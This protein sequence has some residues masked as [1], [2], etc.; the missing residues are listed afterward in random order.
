V[1]LVGR[2]G[3]VGAATFVAPRQIQYSKADLD[4]PEELAR[5]IALAIDNARLYTTA[6]DALRRRDEFLTVAAHEI[7]GPLTSMH[8]AVQG[9]MRGTLAHDGV[10]MALEVIQREDRRLRRFVDDLLDLG[11]IRTGQLAFELED[12]D[13]GSIVR[14]IASRVTTVIAPTKSRVDVAVEGNL[15]GQWDRFRLEQVV[16]NLLT[17]AVKYGQGEPIAISAVETG[18][19]VVLK[20]VDRG[21]GVPPA[22][23]DRIFDPYERAVE[24]RHYGGLGLGLH[25]AKMIVEGLGGAIAVE[26]RL[27]EGTTFTVDL[28]KARSLRS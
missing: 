9:L 13:L 12:V 26:S 2:D 5:R 21:V 23:L 24:T 10:R 8:L 11:R 16:T 3:V 4:L 27:G 6:R 1:P 20:C 18:D 28:P 15:V 7:R 17:N 19:H 22:M 25:I 14:D